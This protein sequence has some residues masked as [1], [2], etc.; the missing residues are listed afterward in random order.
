ME[1]SFEGF[2]DKMK[3]PKKV[4]PLLLESMQKWGGK[5]DESKVDNITN[6]QGQLSSIQAKM[7]QIE[8][9]ILSITNE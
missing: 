6:I 5:N 4:F 1:K 2:I 8:N 9:K 7:K 3:I